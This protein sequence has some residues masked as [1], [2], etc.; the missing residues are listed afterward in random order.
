MGFFFLLQ[1][2]WVATGKKII[3]LYIACP[4]LLI[5]PW[6]ANA[7]CVSFSCVAPTMH[8]CGNRFLHLLHWKWAE[9]GWAFANDGCFSSQTGLFQQ[10]NYQSRVLLNR[11][12]VNTTWHCQPFFTWDRQ[13]VL[14]TLEKVFWSKSESNQSHSVSMESADAFG[15]SVFA[16]HKTLSGLLLFFFSK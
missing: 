13:Q 8:C 15:R 12:G 4:V 10:T 2:L 7:G 14:Q 3:I 6:L 11:A 9:F 5:H 16:G 1:Y